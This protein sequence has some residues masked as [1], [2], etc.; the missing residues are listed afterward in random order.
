[1]LIFLGRCEAEET[2]A[3]TGKPAVFGPKTAISPGKTA[4]YVVY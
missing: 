2:V 3:I 4:W 1:L